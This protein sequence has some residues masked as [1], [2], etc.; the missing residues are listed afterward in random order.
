MTNL[1]AEAGLPAP[2]Y[3]TEDFFTA[4]L[5]KKRPTS[6]QNVIENVIENVGEKLIGKAKREKD[7]LD[8][9]R[10]HP[11]ISIAELAQSLGVTERT[12]ARDI[13]HLQKSNRLTRR[14]GYK[15]GSWKIL[16]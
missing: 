15:G 2:E 6:S 14:G 8:M 4:V 1:L 11:N 5:Y 13:A 9:M 12:I 7:I 3:R 10:Q 16:K